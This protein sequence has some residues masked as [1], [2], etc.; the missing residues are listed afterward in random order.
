MVA[1]RIETNGTVNK[2]IFKMVSKPLAE[3]S[4]NPNE[5]HESMPKIIV[6]ANIILFFKISKKIILIILFIAL[7]FENFCNCF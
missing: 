4:S 6:Y 2:I 5:L 3:L 7:A 1:K